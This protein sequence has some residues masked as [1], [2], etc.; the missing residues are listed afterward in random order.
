MNVNV[1]RLSV[2]RR[3]CFFLPS[4]SSI[5]TVEAITDHIPTNNK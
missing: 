4:V 5:R 3:C 1:D 2:D